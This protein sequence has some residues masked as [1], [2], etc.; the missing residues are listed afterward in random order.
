MMDFV[1]RLLVGTWRQKLHLIENH[2][3]ALIIDLVHKKKYFTFF[4]P[5][6]ILLDTVQKGCLHWEYAQL[7]PKNAYSDTIV[8]RRLFSVYLSVYSL[9]CLVVGLMA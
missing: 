7:I 1:I 8:M 3:A 9:A 6:G 4:D 5:G 2:P